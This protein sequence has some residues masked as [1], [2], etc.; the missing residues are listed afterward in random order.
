MQQ[1]E[2]PLLGRHAGS[3]LTGENDGGPNLS[4]IPKVK[5]GVFKLP[6]KE[7]PVD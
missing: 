4:S 6:R 3:A 5:D 1:Q 2:R 7:E